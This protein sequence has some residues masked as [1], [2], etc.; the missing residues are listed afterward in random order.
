M[1]F[2]ND[3]YKNFENKSDRRPLYGVRLKIFKRYL[4]NLGKIYVN[5]NE[6]NKKIIF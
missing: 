2:D 6:I 5:L 1:T 4:T 3:F